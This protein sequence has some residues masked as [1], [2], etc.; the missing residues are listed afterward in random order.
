MLNVKVK[1]MG[2]LIAGATGMLALGQSTMGCAFDASREVQEG[3]DEPLAHQTQAVEPGSA[4]LTATVQYY[5]QQEISL[6]VTNPTTDEF[7]R[8]GEKLKVDFRAVDFWWLAHPNGGDGYDDINRLKKLNVQVT[9]HFYQNGSL[10]S[11]SAVGIASWSNASSSWELVGTTQEFTVPASTDLVR[12]SYV[13]TDAD[14][15]SVNVQFTQDQADRLVVFGARPEKHVV[16]DND[17]SDLRERVIEDGGL[18]RGRDILVG[19]TD[20]RANTVADTSGI[21]TEI[22]KQKNYGRFGADIIPIHGMIEHEVTMGVQFN[23]VWGQEAPM[24]QR[25]DSA[26]VPR[27]QPWNRR[28]SFERRVAIPANAN[29]VGMYFHVKT[30]L[31]VDY[32]RYPNAVEKFY[33]DGE[34]ILV[35]DVWDNNGGNGVDYH[36]ATENSTLPAVQPRPANVRRTVIFVQGET[37]PGQDM[38]VRGGLDHTVAQVLLGKSCTD[39]QGNPDYSCSIPITL[40]NRKNAY[41]DPWKT[42]DSFLD[43]YGV[44][45]TQ[46]GQGANGTAADWTTNYWPSEWGPEKTVANDGY[47]VEALNQYC[48]M[49][50]WMVDVEMDCAKAY[51]SPDGTPWFEVKSFISNGPGWEP[52]VRQGVDSYYGYSPAPYASKNHM[53]KCGMVNVFRRGN[54]SAEF[55]RFDQ[56]TH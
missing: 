19:Y 6:T 9:A 24:V 33:A 28:F 43:W 56:L 54:S 5:N 23:D 2:A 42:G 11:S 48:G 45:S 51:H 46:T 38:F 34:R 31:K 7:I 55:Y 4:T 13:V 53:G 40:L 20:H 26:M 39:R 36:F 35:R 37:S 8:V 47:G 17:F 29:Q 3:D 27:S 10:K 30:Y 44:E 41:T 50:C 15:S 49:H 1:K 21:N 22:G 14:D 16:F 52:D 25:L 18:P 12:F 32:S